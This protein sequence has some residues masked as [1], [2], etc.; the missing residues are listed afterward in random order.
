MLKIK[1]NIN[2]F[3][4][5][6]SELPIYGDSLTK[7]DENVVIP[8]NDTYHVTVSDIIS[9]IREDGEEIYF[10]EDRNVLSIEKGRTVTSYTVK[11]FPDIYLKI[12]SC[13]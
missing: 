5:R 10:Q 1:S 2:D 11:G 9:F 4:L 12:D 3:K 7:L 13:V 8:S 6:Y